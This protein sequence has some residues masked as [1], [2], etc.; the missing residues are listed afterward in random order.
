MPE[1]SEVLQKK[2]TALR[3][4]MAYILDNLV[5]KHIFGSR[6]KAL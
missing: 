2:A 5:I 6:Q 3:G 4:S 1:K